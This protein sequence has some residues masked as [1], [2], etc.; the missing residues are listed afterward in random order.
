M[1][2]W[3]ELPTNDRIAKIRDLAR[4]GL[5]EGQIESILGAPDGSIR[6]IARRLGF[7]L[8]SERQRKAAEAGGDR[9]AIAGSNM[10]AADE[11]RRRSMVARKASK[12]ASEALRAFR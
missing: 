5:T 8:Q 12:G 10:W 7:I 3:A 6:T 2:I 9:G 4:N 11:D 1:G